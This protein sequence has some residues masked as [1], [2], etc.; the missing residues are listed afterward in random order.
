M[1]ALISLFSRR[2]PGP[3]IALRGLRVLAIRAQ[4]WRDISREATLEGSH[5][6]F[7]QGGL[8]WGIA[9]FILS[10]VMLF[11]SL[12][13]AYFHFSLVPLRGIGLA[14]PPVSLVSFRAFQLPFLNTLILLGRGVTLT[15]GH[16]ALCCQRAFLTKVALAGTIGLGLYF[17][18]LQ[19][20]E[21][22]TG[23]FSLQDSSYGSIFFL[24][25]GT[26][27]AHVLVGSLFLAACLIRLGK[28][29]FRG[30][31]HFGFEASAWYWHFVDVVWLVLFTVFYY[32]GAYLCGLRCWIRDLKAQKVF[33]NSLF[34]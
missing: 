31:R 15:L 3:F 23:A 7:S 5:T 9:L 25:T 13:W 26:H 2:S 19:G 34:D 21:Y 22:M 17:T 29:H 1:L 4:W 32:W 16:H 33:N 20:L 18:F 24:A 27:G 14:W 28:G 6:R 30:T 12:F 10:E 11:F 8:T